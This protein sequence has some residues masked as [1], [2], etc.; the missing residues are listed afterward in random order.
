MNCNVYSYAY[1]E[2]NAMSI[3]VMLILHNW[4]VGFFSFGGVGG[5]YDKTTKRKDCKRLSAFLKASI[6]LPAS[7]EENKR[8]TEI[9]D[10]PLKWWANGHFRTA[11]VSLCRRHREE[12]RRIFG[13][14]VQYVEK[15]IMCDLWCCAFPLNKSHSQMA[16]KIL[17]YCLCLQFQLETVY[18]QNYF[19]KSLCSSV[20]CLFL[21]LNKSLEQHSV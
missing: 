4:T 11:A 17:N 12:T 20:E 13:K 6:R 15:Y 9:R 7:Q 1:M 5:R 10:V 8:K 2:I 18:K 16:C 3:P 21:L 14:D 19:C